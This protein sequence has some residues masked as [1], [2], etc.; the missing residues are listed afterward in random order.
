MRVTKTK[1]SWP[2]WDCH[3]IMPGV[4][5]G[6]KECVPVCTRGGVRTRT[7]AGLQDGDHPRTQVRDSG[8][9]ALMNNFVVL[10]LQKETGLGNFYRRFLLSKCPRKRGTILR[11]FV[12]YLQYFVVLITQVRKPCHESLYDIYVVL[13]SK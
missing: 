8:T 3:F 1:N 6:D 10:K 11:D 9:R 5:R 7:Q 2:P 4:S 12:Q 13:L